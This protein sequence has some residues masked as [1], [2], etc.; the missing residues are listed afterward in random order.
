MKNEISFHIIIF[1]VVSFVF[2]ATN[3]FV[4]CENLHIVGTNEDGVTYYDKD[5]IH[6][7]KRDNVSV[8]VTQ[9]YS[10]KYSEDMGNSLLI[11]RTYRKPY[12]KM[13][14]IEINCKE[15]SYRTIKYII[16]DVFENILLLHNNKS[17]IPT[18]DIIPYS[19]MDKLRVSLCK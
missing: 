18:I 2:Y 13:S 8:W 19:V 15:R 11:D 16:F 17:D 6:I 3:D 12:S 14:L 5:S 9:M 10:K 1:F 4:Y 7:T